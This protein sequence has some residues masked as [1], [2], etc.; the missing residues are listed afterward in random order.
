MKQ[1]QLQNKLLMNKLKSGGGSANTTFPPLNVKGNN[2]HMITGKYNSELSAAK[3][4]EKV[5]KRSHT[6]TSMRSE[7][8][9]A[10]V[11]IQVAL[12]DL[13]WE[14]KELVLRVL[15]SKMNSAES[16]KVKAGMQALQ[17]LDLG[18]TDDPP[19]FIS[20]GAGL[21]EQVGDGAGQVPH[22]F[23]ASEG[24]ISLGELLDMKTKLSS[25]DSQSYQHMEG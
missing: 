22:D 2:L 19:V 25:A 14:D 13:T 3:A 24:S 11:H 18:Q 9:Y 17:Q 8:G 10:I 4:D 16:S 23:N 12:K 7:L 1:S 5:T 20:Q 21:Q 6:H 15:F